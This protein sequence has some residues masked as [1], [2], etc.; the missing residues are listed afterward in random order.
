MKLNNLDSKKTFHKS[1]A[2]TLIELLVVISIIALLMSIMM[3]A[4]GRARKMAK[5]TVCKTRLKQMGMSI[6]L[7]AADN[8]GKYVTQDWIGS[9]GDFER[10]G[11]WFYRLSVYIDDVKSDDQI[12]DFMRCPSGLAR[13]EYKGGDAFG[14]SAVDY[15]LKN[16]HRADIRR[17]STIIGVP[18]K[19]AEIRQPAKFATVV[20]WY[21]GSKKYADS[22]DVYLGSGNTLYESG[23]DG[24]VN[25]RR[26]PIFRKLVFRHNN[27][28]NTVFADGSVRPIK[29]RVGSELLTDD[30]YRLEEP[31]WEDI[32]PPLNNVKYKVITE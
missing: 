24:T 10:E 30:F 31:T 13:T 7:Y 25:N 27:A 29:M 26:A 22:F 9:T 14:W 19:I 4:L 32:H 11:Y 8:N 21:L 16:F 28:M 17:G 3:P 5:S 15:I 6:E 2:F 18:R 20:D 23:W 1:K 12:G